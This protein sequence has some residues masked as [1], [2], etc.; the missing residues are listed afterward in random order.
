MKN[1]LHLAL[2]L[3]AAALVGCAAPG[4]IAPNTSADVLVQKLG[5]PSDTR[6]NPQ[7]GE[8]WDYVYGPEGF[9]T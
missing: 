1:I 8:Y 7:G 6:R 4:S 5:K 3:V 2:W 9:D